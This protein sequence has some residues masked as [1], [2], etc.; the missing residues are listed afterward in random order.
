VKTVL[1]IVVAALASVVVWEEASR[2]YEVYDI[3]STSNCC[4]CKLTVVVFDSWTGKTA[5]RSV[6]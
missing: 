6:P 2:R 4:A 1:L 3:S 5:A